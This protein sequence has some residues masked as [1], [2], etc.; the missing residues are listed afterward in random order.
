MTH[1]Q[2]YFGDDLAQNNVFSY[3]GDDK[4]DSSINK[5]S[6]IYN[7]QGLYTIATSSWLTINAI[8]PPTGPLNIGRVR[9]IKYFVGTRSRDVKK[10][11]SITSIVACLSKKP[12]DKR[13]LKFKSS[14]LS[15]IQRLRKNIALR[16]KKGILDS[17]GFWI[18]RR[19]FRIPDTV[20]TG[21]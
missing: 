17:L 18:L 15:K 5:P 14:R 8:H 13:L 21:I 2:F 20:K 7:K 12:S 10:S 4:V 3:I 6:K 11:Q 1:G 9:K 19:G 16:P